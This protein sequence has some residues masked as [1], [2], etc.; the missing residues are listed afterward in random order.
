MTPSPLSGAMQ[1]NKAIV[2]FID[3]SKIR[4]EDLFH[5]D[6]RRFNSSLSA[7]QRPQA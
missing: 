2:M 3:D 6:I 7:L 5:G 4:F 1:S